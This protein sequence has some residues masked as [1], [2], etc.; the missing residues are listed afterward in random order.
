MTI[1]KVNLAFF[2]ATGTTNKI[3]RGVES[4]IGVNNTH[5]IDLANQSSEPIII[6]N[7]EIVIFGVPVFSGRVP[8]IARRS[9]E[10][11]SGNNTPAIVVCVYGNRDF[12]DAL[13]E[14]K[15]L[16]ESNG[17]CVLSAGAFIA[18]HSIFPMVAHGR[19]DESDLKQARDFGAES[20][21]DMT[22]KMKNKPFAVKGNNPYRAIKRI[23]LTPK[24]SSSCNSCKLCTKQCPVLAIDSNNPKKIDKSKCISCAHCISI[25]PNQS[26]KFGGLI[27]WIA[28]K[29][30][31][32][33]Y[34]Q[35]REAYL[36]HRN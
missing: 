28:S 25:C 19:P 26:K 34:S 27:Y 23:P 4:G 21:R 16:V 35:R 10:K 24:T 30:F 29:K 12:D 36:T 2:S 20:V 22:A 15:E 17:F 5:T 3:V 1:Q 32:K 11:I 13:L 8:E 7:D 18:Q 9:I 31:T 14:L 33:N 6:P